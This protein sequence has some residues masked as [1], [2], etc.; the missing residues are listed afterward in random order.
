MSTAFHLTRLL[1]D[2][3]IKARAHYQVWWAL[4]NRALPKY[5]DTMNNSAYVDF[6]HAANSGHYTLFLLSLSKIF[7]RDTRVAGIKELKLA[8]RAE[9][10]TNIANEIARMLKPHEKHVR[11]VMGIRNR[12]V[13]HNEY[14][15]S[16]EKVYQLNGVTPNQL[17]DLI[18]ATCQAINLAARDLGIVNPIFDSDRTERATLKMLELLAMGA[19]TKRARPASGVA[20]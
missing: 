9:G 7:D 12:S 16:I 14:A 20:E 18:D 19:K 5:L 1:I 8:L 6:F 4:R 3:G 11:S 17:R 13:V 10:K 15:V 2:E